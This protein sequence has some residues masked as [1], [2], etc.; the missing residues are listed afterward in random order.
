[1]ILLESLEHDHKVSFKGVKCILLKQVTIR[2]KDSGPQGQASHNDVTSSDIILVRA[3]SNHLF[4]KNVSTP[5]SPTP[6]FL[7]TFPLQIGTCFVVGMF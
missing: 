6:R 4:V 7:S 5:N 1:M 2:P 3:V